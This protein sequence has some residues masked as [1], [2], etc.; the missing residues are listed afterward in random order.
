MKFIVFLGNLSVGQH[1]L[2]NTTSLIII[3]CCWSNFTHFPITLSFTALVLSR[4]MWWL[5]YP[6]KVSFQYVNQ[7]N[8]CPK[9]KT[10]MEKWCGMVS[11][12]TTVLECTWAVAELYI[13]SQEMFYQLREGTDNVPM[14]DCKFL[15]NVWPISSQICKFALFGSV[16]GL[17]IELRHTTV[18]T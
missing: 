10:K 11:N 16:K 15:S 13:T 8:S 6:L 14:R 3:A 2:G 18:T 7:G 4:C 1:V 12:L 5:Y 17:Y 9:W